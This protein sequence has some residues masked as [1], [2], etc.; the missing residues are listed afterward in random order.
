MYRFAEWTIIRPVHP[1]NTPVHQHFRFAPQ[2]FLS[3]ARDNTQGKTLTA[4]LLQTATFLPDWDRYRT[5][6]NVPSCRQP[7]ALSAGFSPRK[8]K[9]FLLFSYIPQTAKQNVCIAN[10]AKSEPHPLTG[11]SNHNHE[12]ES[13]HF[14]Q[15]CHRHSPKLD[16]HP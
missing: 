4:K 1:Q 11:I 13:I 8:M 3:Y 14:S 16:D 2:A 6:L 7:R 15:N 10:N 9:I 12:F 5:I